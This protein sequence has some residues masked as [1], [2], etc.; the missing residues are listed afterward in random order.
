M[1]IISP[2]IHWSTPAWFHRH[3]IKMQYEF[4]DPQRQTLLLKSSAASVIIRK[5]SW[6]YSDV[7]GWLVNWE[8]VQFKPHEV[9][10]RGRTWF[11]DRSLERAFYLSDD[12]GD[13]LSEWLLRRFGA[14]S[15]EQGKFIRWRKFLNIPC[16]GTGNDGD[17]NVSIYIDEEI[18]NAVRQL[19]NS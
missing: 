10:S 2:E 19:L 3:G 12:P 1:K 11:S 4:F 6:V 14:D 15:A 9:G 17:P 7:E 5:A 8:I 13:G 16:P 18:Q